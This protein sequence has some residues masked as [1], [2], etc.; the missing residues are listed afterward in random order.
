MAPFAPSV[1]MTIAPVHCERRV[2]I[3]RAD[4]AASSSSSS[5]GVALFWESAYPHAALRVLAFEHL[6]QLVFVHHQRVQLSQRLGRDAPAG[7]GVARDER[8]AR[9]A[10]NRRG[11]LLER[12]L[13]LRQQHRPVADESS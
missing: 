5:A 10:P 9:R 4:A 13:H 11:G 7:R 3:A 12:N 2:A 6:L 8:A 1:T